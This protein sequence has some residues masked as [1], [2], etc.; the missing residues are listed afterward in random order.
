MLSHLSPQTARDSPFSIFPNDAED[1]Q[2]WFHRQSQKQRT[3]PQ[4]HNVIT[5]QCAR[6]SNN[7][8]F[9]Y[10][11]P[12]SAV[13]QPHAEK[14]AWSR[15]GLDRKTGLEKAGPVLSAP[16]K[17]TAGCHGDM[18]QTSMSAHTPLHSQK[19]FLAPTGRT[20]PESNFSRPD[21]SEHHQYTVGQL[22]KCGKSRATRRVRSSIL[23]CKPKQQIQQTADS[24]NSCMS[25]CFILQWLMCCLRIIFLISQD[26]INLAEMLSDY[27]VQDIWQN[28][29]L[30]INFYTQKRERSWV[31]TYTHKYIPLVHERCTLCR[32][33]SCTNKIGN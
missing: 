12:T 25:Q 26:L 21:M 10:L 29:I 24:A 31:W 7:G 4:K 1:G 28:F 3:L 11:F 14:L 22:P 6:N 8:L 30:P 9:Q 15:A 33:C 23:K 19:W 2:T 27:I 18:P 13:P 16:G 32:D 20:V 17:W 5:S